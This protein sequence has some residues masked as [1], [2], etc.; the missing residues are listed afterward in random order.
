MQVDHQVD[1][2]V[3]EAEQQHDALDHRIVAAQDRIDGQPAEARD[4]EHALG[5]HRAAD[6]QRDADADHG[7]DRHGGVLQRV[8]EQDAALAEA[9]GARGADIVL[10]QHLEH[11]GA[12]DAG[13]QRDV[14]E[15]ERDRRQ[16]QVLA[17]TAR[18]PSRSG[19]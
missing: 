3:D 10:L 7:D 8:H 19:V 14:D 15:A 9:L 17:A 13:D 18:S 12:R 1:Q 6:Q 16:D 4:G 11:G 5:H 2:H